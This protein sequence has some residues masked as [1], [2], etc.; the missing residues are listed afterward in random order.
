MD[1]KEIIT[2]L[3]HATIDQAPVRII[4][5][6]YL[7]SDFHRISGTISDLKITC[8]LPSDSLVVLD[9][10]SRSIFIYVRM[11]K[12]ITMDDEGTLVILL[13]D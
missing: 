1:T 12:D 4:D 6:H 8:C 9:A 3:T 7:A 11:I 13:G 2:F 10:G 5:P